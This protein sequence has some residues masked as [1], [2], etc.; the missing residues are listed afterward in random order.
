M[1]LAVAP[2]DHACATFATDTDQ[3]ALVG[4]FARDAF[5]RGDRVFYLAD[6]SDEVQVT[7]FLD[8]AGVDGRA[9]L[10]AGDLHI[11]HSSQMGLEDG[12]ERDRQMAVWQS[13]IDSAQADGYRGLAVAVEMTWA[14]RWGVPMSALIDY[15]A[16]S[17]AVFASRAM[18]AV[19]QYDS[20]FFDPATIESAH[21]AHPYSMRI[22]GEDFDARYTR[23]AVA[24]DDR[25]RS[26]RLIG[27][28][29]LGNVAFLDFE[30]DELQKTGPLV[31]DC[32]RLRFI[33][34]AGCR[35]L[36]RGVQAG[37]VELRNPPPVVT[38]VMNLINW[39]E[40]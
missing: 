3:A 17:E 30:L 31:V 33:D 13:L 32:T 29:D 27:E 20:R 36:H 22:A 12:F 21:L 8:H 35:L 10:G 11:L 5:A 34:V 39:V 16:T 9:R 15:E 4:G 25:D 28:I 19:C 6:R 1:G 7:A 37:T 23:L 2:G 40:R 24:W 38:R 18:S 14:L 26:L